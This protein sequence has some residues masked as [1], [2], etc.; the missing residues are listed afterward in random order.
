MKTY[1]PTKNADTW[2]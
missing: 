1:R 2:G